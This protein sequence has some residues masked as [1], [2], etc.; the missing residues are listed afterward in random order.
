MQ[1]GYLSLWK[2]FGNSSLSWIEGCFYRHHKVY[3]SLPLQEVP[4][5][6]EAGVFMLLVG[7]TNSNAKNL[8]PSAKNIAKNIPSPAKFKIFGIPQ[9]P[10]K[11]PIY[12][13]SNN[14]DNCNLPKTCPKMPKISVPL[15]NPKFLAFHRYPHKCPIYRLPGNLTGLAS[16]EIGFVYRTKCKYVLKSTV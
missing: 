9:I 8:C 5:P 13:L 16:L 12:R 14:S 4:L 1:K 7:F 3:L 6:I 11:C 10:M 2:S 15:P